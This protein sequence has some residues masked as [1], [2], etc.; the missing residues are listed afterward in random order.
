MIKKRLDV[1]KRF[2]NHAKINGRQNPNNSYNT[3]KLHQSVSGIPMV[4]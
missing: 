2:A 4:L 3:Q 1:N